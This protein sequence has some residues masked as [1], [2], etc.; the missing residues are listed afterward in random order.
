M[1]T[2][3][4]MVARVYVG[5]GRWVRAH[6]SA[7]ACNECEALSG[8]AAHVTLAGFQH[9]GAAPRVQSYRGDQWPSI[10]L[11]DS[12]T[13]GMSRRRAA[14]RFDDK[15]PPLARLE[16][17]VSETARERKGRIMS[18][19]IIELDASADPGPW[20]AA[21]RSLEARALIS[22]D[23]AVHF[24]E[25]FLECISFRASTIDSEMLRISG[26]KCSASRRRMA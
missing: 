11:S 22:F 16:S 15:R 5:N 21:A 2:V 25:R 1:V 12:V 17:V 8:R 9:S 19:I 20:I 18:R 6:S 26:L 4:G 23:A 14:P 10:N 7:K 13:S 24:A 3:T